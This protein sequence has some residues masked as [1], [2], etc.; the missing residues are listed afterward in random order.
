[1]SCRR[2]KR[3][4]R[5]AFGKMVEFLRKRASSCRILLVE[6]TDRLYRNIK[7]WVTIDELGIEVHFVKE[8]VVLSEDSR[9]SEKFMH[10]IKVLIAKNSSTTLAREVRKGM[11][12]KARQGHW[13]TVARSGIRTT[14][15][16]IASSP[17]LSALRSSP[18]SSSGTRQTSIR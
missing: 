14:S 6:Q 2:R 13:P 7:D 16:R 18:N 3:G 10:G 9:S 4:G 15:R 8:N 5:T 11:I 1:M 17:I 12:E